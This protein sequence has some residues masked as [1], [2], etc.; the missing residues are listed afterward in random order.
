MARQQGL[1][2]KE[3]T[4]ADQV[5]QRYELEAGTPYQRTLTDLA[6]IKLDRH[7]KHCDGYALTTFDDGSQLVYTYETGKYSI[8]PTAIPQ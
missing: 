6:I 2:M 3:P 4:T 8:P 1:D 7:I 5:M